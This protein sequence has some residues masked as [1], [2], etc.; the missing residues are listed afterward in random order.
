MSQN[1]KS[2]N[3]KIMKKID[4]II[5]SRLQIKKKEQFIKKSKKKEYAFM[6]M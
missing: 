4:V 2:E 6:M 5:H 1:I 3:A